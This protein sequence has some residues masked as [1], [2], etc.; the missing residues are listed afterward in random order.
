MLMVAVITLMN[1]LEN[2][3]TRTYC[4]ELSGAAKTALQNN[5]LRMTPSVVD[6]TSLSFSAPLQ[7][8]VCSDSQ[9]NWQRGAGD[10]DMIL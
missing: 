2:I 5:M 1:S 3:L 7:I 10:E 8:S 9:E 4:Q 6:S